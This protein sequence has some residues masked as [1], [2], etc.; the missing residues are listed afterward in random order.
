[1]TLRSKLDV[2]LVCHDAGTATF[3]VNS[4]SDHFLIEPNVIQYIGSATVGTSA[5]SISGPTVLST[6]VVK[7]EGAQPLRLAGTIDVSAG[8]VAVLPVTATVTVASVS[9]QGSYTALW[10]G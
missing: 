7:N 2:D 10:V 4:V 9:G 1:M 3:V 6:L 8:R 5:I